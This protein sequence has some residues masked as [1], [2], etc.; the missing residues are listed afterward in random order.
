MSSEKSI[1]LQYVPETHRT[2]PGLKTSHKDGTQ[3]LASSQVLSLLWASVIGLES[4]V[5][6]SGSKQ[7]GSTPIFCSEKSRPSVATFCSATLPPFCQALGFKHWG[8]LGSI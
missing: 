2:L 6:E 8:L 4:P 7:F 5:V 3:R 1:N